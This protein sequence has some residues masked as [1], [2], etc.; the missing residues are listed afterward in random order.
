VRNRVLAAVA[1]LATATV[2]AGSGVTAAGWS[3]VATIPGTS[4]RSGLLDLRVDGQDAVA[5][6]APLDLSLLVPGRTTA[7]VLSV[8]NGGNVNLSYTLAT[9]G[10][11][12]DGAHLLG[13]LALK[14]TAA[15]TTTPAASGAT[16]AGTALPGSTGS[17]GGPLVS[18]PRTLA[19]G[20]SE[21][22]CVQVLLP[23]SAPASV[24]G[25]VTDLTITADAVLGGWSDSVAVAGS[26][27]ATAALTAPTISCGLA[28]L[29]EI[30]VS[31][32]AVPGATAYRIHSGLLGGT[33]TTVSA[34]TLSATFVA[35][36]GVVSVEAVLGSSTWVSPPSTSLVY[37]AVSGLGSCS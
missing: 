12:P 28:A 35:T 33:L 4:M 10:T 26:R 6:Y 23:S 17:A 11:D 34:D 16:C 29:L 24:A 15:T 37:S 2:L 5:D 7:A 13:A 19:P 1:G 8:A 22:L 31:W 18:T 20:S 27:L 9:S 32:T 3:D 36:S 30:T 21:L 25:A 14:V